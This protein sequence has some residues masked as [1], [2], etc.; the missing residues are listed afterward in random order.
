MIEGRLTHACIIL[1]WVI[2][3]SSRR[4]ALHGSKISVVEKKALLVTVVTW[5]GGKLMTQSSFLGL[6]EMRMLTGG[7][8]QNT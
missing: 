8:G 4:K 5:K 2:A 3:L 7:S 6:S 1:V